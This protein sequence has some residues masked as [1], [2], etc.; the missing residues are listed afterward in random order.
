M[1]THFSGY[2]NP[3]QWESEHIDLSKQSAQ[4]YTK[5]DS[6]CLLFNFWVIKFTVIPKKSFDT[7]QFGKI[8]VLVNFIIQNWK[9]N[10]E[11]VSVFSGNSFLREREKIFSTY[12]GPKSIL[13]ISSSWLQKFLQQKNPPINRSIVNDLI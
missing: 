12:S 6:L 8:G 13:K 3:I 9:V 2:S 7:C 11:Y 1:I 4:L 10:N 5:V